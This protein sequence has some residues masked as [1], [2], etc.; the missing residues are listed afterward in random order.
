METNTH[1]ALRPLPLRGTSFVLLRLLSSVV[2]L[3][4]DIDTDANS[5]FKTVIALIFTRAARGNG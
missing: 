5:D 1:V 2:I 4:A 3:A